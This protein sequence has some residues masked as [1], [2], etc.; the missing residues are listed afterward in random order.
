MTFFADHV[1]ILSEFGKMVGIPDVAF[2]QDGYCCLGFD[3]VVLNI[4]HNET[5]RHLLVFSEVA[6]LPAQPNK[7]LLLLLLKL[8]YASLVMGAGGISIDEHAGTI[9]F[10]ERIPLRG[11]DNVAFEA[12]M[13]SIVDRVE[14][15]KTA[16]SDPDF[17]SSNTT[18]NASDLPPTFLLRQC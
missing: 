16:M 9:M 15:L 17:V 14:A 1:E 4:E 2:D 11:L 6:S 18:L 8:N 3:D 10:V 13:R 7:S 5:F 12:A